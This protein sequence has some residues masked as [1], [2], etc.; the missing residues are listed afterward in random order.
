MSG[1]L[2]AGLAEYS[3]YLWDLVQADPGRLLTLLNA[4]P[5]AHFRALL[6]HAGADQPCLFLRAKH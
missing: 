5:K 1:E 2:V 4:D 3:P 6:A